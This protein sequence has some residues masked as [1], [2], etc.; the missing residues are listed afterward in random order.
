MVTVNVRNLK[1][2]LSEYI[3]RA[4]HGEHVVVLRDG[5]PV[6]RLVPMSPS[7]DRT[8][9]EIIARLAAQGLVLLPEAEGDLEPPDPQVTTRGDLLASDMVAADRR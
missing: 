8:A 5:Q 7:T 4:E 3:G 6:A 1:D 9:D 2:R